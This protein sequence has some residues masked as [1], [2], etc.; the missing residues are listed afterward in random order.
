[1]ALRIAA[2]ELQLAHKAALPFVADD[3]FINFDDARSK[4]G[5]EALRELSSR[6]QV[7][8]LTHHDHLLPLVREVFG[9]GVNV[10]ELQRERV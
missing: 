4:A 8:F 6:T 2:L 7:L 1:L 10:V 9:A 5:L 3:L